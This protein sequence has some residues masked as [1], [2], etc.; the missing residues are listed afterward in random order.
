M[1][2]AIRDLLE[3]ISE[4]EWAV[5]QAMDLPDDFDVAQAY[6]EWETM[7]QDPTWIIDPTSG[8]INFYDWLQDSK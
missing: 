3:R 6:E 8:P 1:S 4:L 5:K 7:T 2:A